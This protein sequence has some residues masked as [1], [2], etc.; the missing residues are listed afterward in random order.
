[1]DMKT[2]ELKIS[3]DIYDTVIAFFEIFPKDK[4]QI[5]YPQ[6]SVESQQKK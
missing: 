4:I 3:S 5:I 6:P 1:M 2:I